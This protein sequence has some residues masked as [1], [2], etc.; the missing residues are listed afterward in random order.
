[1]TEPL[2]TGIKLIDALLALG[3]GQRELIVGDRETGKTAIAT[4]AIINQRGSDVICVYVAVGQ[5]SSSVRQVI[6]AVHA[7]TAIPSAASS[8]SRDRRP[9]RACSGSRRTPASRWRS[10]FATRA[11]TSLIVIDDLT[12][13][14]ATHRE[15]SLLMRQPSG[16]RGLSGRRLPHPR[17][18]AGAGGQALVANS[19]ADR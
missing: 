1:M 8:W 5:K 6:D 16:T 2:Q 14:A 11:A 3:R 4:D 17:P 10:T 7:S 9:R 13:H 18:P 12:K 19:A 15:L